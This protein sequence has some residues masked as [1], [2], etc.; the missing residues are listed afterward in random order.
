MC[1]REAVVQTKSKLETH[2]RKHIRKQ[3]RRNTFAFIIS[4]PK[5][6]TK[7]LRKSYSPKNHH[8]MQNLKQ[9][10]PPK[11]PWFW[12]KNSVSETGT[13]I[14]YTNFSFIPIIFSNLVSKIR[15][16]VYFF[17]ITL[18]SILQRF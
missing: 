12:S 8:K 18:K 16:A 4:S 1:Q 9:K 10:I 17:T 14:F 11:L 7:E 5:N 2:S 15:Y 6:K 13:S 3:I